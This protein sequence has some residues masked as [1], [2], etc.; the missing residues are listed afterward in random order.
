MVTTHFAI[1]AVGQHGQDNGVLRR[2]SNRSGWAFTSTD[3]IAEA[4]RFI[5]R[6]PAPVI[7]CESHLPD[8]DWRDLLEAAARRG[9]RVNVIVTS[10]L[11]D[12]RL[13]DEVLSLG[14]YDVLAT[15]LDRSEVIRAVES[16]SRNGHYPAAAQGETATAGSGTHRPPGNSAVNTDLAGCVTPISTPSRRVACEAQAPVHSC[17]TNPSW[18]KLPPARM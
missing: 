14:G 18:W 5:E 8:G 10:R 15:P 3:T 7:F 2:V 16:A 13:W 4:M 6:N 9:R 12:E 1:L 17:P 11:A